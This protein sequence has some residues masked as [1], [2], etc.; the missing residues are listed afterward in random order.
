MPAAAADA[1]MYAPAQQLR[2]CSRL[3]V[4]CAKQTSTVLND[5]VESLYGVCFV[6]R[7]GY[8]VS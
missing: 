7:N 6:D 3:C 1:P 4:G 5:R 2:E 8:V